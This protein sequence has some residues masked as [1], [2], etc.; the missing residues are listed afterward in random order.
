MNI[1]IFTAPHCVYCRMTKRFLD[2]HKVRYEEIN[3]MESKKRYEEM[4]KKSHQS[5][6]PVVEVGEHI[7]V[8]FHTTEL[9]KALGINRSLVEKI[10]AKIKRKHKD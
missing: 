3:V 1:K 7:F 2:M 4:V 8:G 5:G 9:A 10:K 6:V